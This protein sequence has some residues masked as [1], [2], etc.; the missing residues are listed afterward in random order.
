VFDIV[1]WMDRTLYSQYTNNWNDHFF[2]N[3][4]VK[5]LKSDYHLLDLGAGAGRVAQ[6]NFRGLVAREP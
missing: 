3:E 1:N 2:R 5:V 6:M 4:I